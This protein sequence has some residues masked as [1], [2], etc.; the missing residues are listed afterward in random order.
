M[1]LGSSSLIIYCF[2]FTDGET[3][4]RVLISRL[5]QTARIQTHIHLTSK[6]EVLAVA[7][8]FLS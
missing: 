4:N 6:P 1:T 8:Y 3:G 2:H 5:G 7:L